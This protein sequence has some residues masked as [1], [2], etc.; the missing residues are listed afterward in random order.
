MPS[1]NAE[2]GGH[3]VDMARRPVTAWA[4]MGAAIEYARLRFPRLAHDGGERGAQSTVATSYTMFSPTGSTACRRGR[5]RS[6]WRRLREDRPAQDPG[7]PGPTR[8]CSALLD[9][10]GP[11]ASCRDQVLPPVTGTSRARPVREARHDA[12]PEAR[13]AGSSGTGRLASSNKPSAG[14]GRS[15]RT[16]Q[17]TVSYRKCPRPCVRRGGNRPRRRPQQHHAVRTKSGEG[18]ADSA[19]WPRYRM[20]TLAVTGSILDPDPRA[21]RAFA[22]RSANSRPA[23]LVEAIHRFR[24]R[25][26]VSKAGAAAG[27]RPPIPLRMG[28]IDDPP[29]AQLPGHG[30]GMHGPEPPKR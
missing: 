9:E 11:A 3:G 16:R 29:D 4:I 17:V 2:P 8:S 19:P 14:A 18:N 22:S 28:G 23:A 27:T 25:T 7:R 10:R 5:D 13:G 20:S 12:S 1:Q 30:P 26:R 15:A 21:S 24:P 6:S